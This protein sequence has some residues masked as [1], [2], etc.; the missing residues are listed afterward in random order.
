MEE[1]HNQIRHRKDRTIITTGVGQHQLWAAQYFCWQYS[2]SFITSG[3]MG[4][5][6]FGP[7]AATGAKAANP[8]SLVIDIDGDASFCMT[9]QEVSA[10]YLAS[11]HIK[12]IIIN[13]NEHGMVTE[14]QTRHCG[15][16]Y[17][18]SHQKNPDF[19]LL[20]AS[21]GFEADTC[22]DLD[23]LPAKVDWLLKS[24]NSSLLNVYVK[25]KCALVPVV[26]SGRA[27]DEPLLL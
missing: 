16:R 10:A 17:S 14:W 27:L 4:T 1:V 23:D 19:A 5:M 22:T 21:M 3:S 7:P 18:H 24:E 12:V 15:E 6:G 13:N 9:M 20:A 25:G 8:E 26:E 11:L 2:G